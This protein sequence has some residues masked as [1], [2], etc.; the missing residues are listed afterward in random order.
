MGRQEGM[1]W[2][3]KGH[4]EDREEDRKDGGVRPPLTIGSSSGDLTKE[5]GG[6]AS[7]L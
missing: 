2:G 3:K 1:L 6:E 7:F 5:A 4:Y